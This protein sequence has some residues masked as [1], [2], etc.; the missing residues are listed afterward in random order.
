MAERMYFFDSTEADERIYDAADF[1]R[2]H[3][4]IIGN[5]VSNTQNLPD[6][7]VSAGDNMEI[8]LGAGYCFA[9]GYLYQN[10]STKTL[11]H[12][13]ADTENDRIDRVIIRFDNN[14]EERTIK[15]RILKGTP[16]SNPMPP[17]I[18]RDNYIHDM[19]V[20][21]VLIKAGK[22]YIEDDEITDERANDEVCG[23]IPLHN[24]YRGV[25]INEYG[26]V[27][28]PKQSYVEMD[29]DG[30]FTLDGDTQYDA[31]TYPNFYHTKFKID[32]EIDRQ[33]E[34]NNGKFIAKADGTY[35]FSVHTKLL[36]TSD[37][38]D[39]RKLEAQI[40][41]NNG[42]TD[43]LLYLFNNY[44]TES[45]YMGSNMIYLKKGDVAELTFGRRY[46]ENI[47]LM[48]VRLNIA[49]LN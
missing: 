7:E 40:E 4:Q 39:D 42:G 26:M 16:D 45:Q 24:I 12:D 5:G 36:N 14:P 18:T 29:L 20:A 17:E 38:D 28:M 49:K 8:N 23:Y 3:H 25:Q 48:W 41:I 15:A 47:D 31:E 11:E 37:R 13:I 9:N 35:M 10:D 34:I 2:F 22:S 30:K 1:A 32:A 19:S 33:N 43:G 6:L 27:T 46:K 44:L 21:Q